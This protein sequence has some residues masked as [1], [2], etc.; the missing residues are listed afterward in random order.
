MIIT[1]SG[2]CVCAGFPVSTTTETPSALPAL[3]YASMKNFFV[4]QMMPKHQQPNKKIST[5]LFVGMALVELQQ[6]Y[7]EHQHWH[8][9]LCTSF[10]RLYQNL[11]FI[12]NT[13]QTHSSF[14]GVL[15]YS[16]SSFHCN[17]KMTACYPSIR[18]IALTFF[19]LVAGSSFFA[20]EVA[21]ADIFDDIGDAISAFVEV[22]IRKSLIFYLSCILVF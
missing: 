2:M 11:A 14:V 16:S 15:F 6:Q 13:I 8:L 21:E 5:A 3:F 22:R 9:L 20:P 17:K 7:S 10:S 4:T 12:S 19:L 1:I 18:L